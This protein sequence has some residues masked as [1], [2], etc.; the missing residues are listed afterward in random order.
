MLR[1]KRLARIIE[2]IETKFDQILDEKLGK[3]T[4]P[5]TKIDYS[6]KWGRQN[7]LTVVMDTFSDWNPASV[8]QDFLGVQ[9]WL[10]LGI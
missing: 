6:P 7:G 8:Q 5:R 9:V 3:V 2:N 1:G 4:S 10:Y